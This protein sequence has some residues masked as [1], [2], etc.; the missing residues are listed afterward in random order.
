MTVKHYYVAEVKFECPEN[1]ITL[2][3]NKFKSEMPYDFEVIKATGCILQAGTGA[4]TDTEF[5][6]RNETRGF[7]YYTTR[8]RFRVDDADVN[9][10]AELVDGVL[11]TRV[12]GKQGDVLAL[13]CDGLPGGAD[14]SLA[15]IWLLCGFW[16]EMA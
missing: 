10:R 3:D 8:P 16:R 14:S 12:S 11:G 9:G 6:V 13:D 4:G 1:P 2:G 5:Q 15:T 7:D